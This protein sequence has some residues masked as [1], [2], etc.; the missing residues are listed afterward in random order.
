MRKVA[1]TTARRLGWSH[2]IGTAHRTAGTMGS[3]GCAVL[4]RKGIGISGLHNR[5]IPDAIAHRA[6]IAWVS[7]IAKGGFYLLSIYLKDCVGMN[8]ENQTVCEHVAALV[9][10]L[11]GPCVLGG[12]WNM[13]PASLAKS[14]FLGMV[15]GTI[16]APEL[17]TCNGFFF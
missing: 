1:G 11:D 13:E 17:E 5:A 16:F 15:N 7:A 10:S 2:E 9:R 4:A 6:T 8:S 3:G 14:G 12:D